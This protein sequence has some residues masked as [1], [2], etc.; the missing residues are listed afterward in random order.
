MFDIPSV[1]ILYAAKT[2]QY[3]FEGIVLIGIDMAIVLAFAQGLTKGL[4]SAGKMI[5]TGPFWGNV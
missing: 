5:G 1:I 3:V 2:A 4:N